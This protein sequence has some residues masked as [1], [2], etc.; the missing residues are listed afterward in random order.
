[1]KSRQIVFEI[2]RL[3]DEGYSVRAI[4]KMLGIGRNTVTRYLKDPE[5][6]MA[7]RIKTAS[8]LDPYKEQIDAFLEKDASVSAMVILRKI[9]ALGYEGRITILRGYL[10][11]QRGQQKSRQAFIRFESKPGRQMQIDWGHFGTISYGNTN[12]KLYALVVIESYSRMLYV[13]FAHSQNQQA[14]HGCL[15]NAFKAFGGTPQ[16]IVVDNMLTA[17]TERQSR[18]IRFND[19]FL[20]FLRPF[21]ITPVA[22][23][24][25]APHEKGKV[26]AAVKYLRRNFMPL[27]EFKDLEEINAQVLFWLEK[28][29][30]V[31]EHHG[32]GE[33]PR[34]RFAMVELRKLPEL[35]PEPYECHT[36]MVHKDFAVRFD[37]NTYTV[38]PWA[39]GKKLTLKADQQRIWI[40]NKN[41]QVV[42]YTRCWQRKQRIETEAHVEQVKKLQRKNWQTKEIACFASLGEEFR[43]YLELLPASNLPLKKQVLM[44]LD[45]KDQYGVQSLSVAIMKAMKHKAYGADY[46]ENI[47]YQEMIPQNQHP[48]VKL[49][50]E[51][52]NRIRLTEPTLTDYDAIAL[53]KRK[54]YD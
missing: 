3:K 27:R 7:P 36:L 12:R 47:L 41:K 9:Q 44:L 38:P 30:N 32:T 48:P 39:I 13:E 23:N 11:K 53:K 35:M 17:V 26:E 31:R 40:Y 16:T 29:A 19:A 4:A 37:T 33:V 51:A 1:M 46:I 45:L 6:T 54:K 50:N 34:Q 20:D 15:A 25:G 43:Q 10:R 18:V 42:S 49:K 2:H 5:R 21:H 14:L 24:P 22:C 28:T 52:L 8:K